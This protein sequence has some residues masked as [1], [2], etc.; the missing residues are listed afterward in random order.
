MSEMFDLEEAK[1]YL[2]YEPDTGNFIWLK[3]ASKKTIVGSIAGCKEKRFGYVV[4][5]LNGRLFRAHRLA[6]ALS[7]INIDGLHVD[8]IDGNPSN[9]RLENLRPCTRSQNMKNL[10]P[11]KDNKYSAWKGVSWSPANNNWY[12]RI[13]VDGK[14]RW[15][16]SFS[17]EREAAEAYLFAALDL[18]G[19]YARFA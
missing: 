19:D 5:R 15:L 9:N 16:G 18:Q 1:E 11:H 7:G 12:A 14:S 6:C 8:H 13:F 10:K 3:K 4:I 2:R 17:D